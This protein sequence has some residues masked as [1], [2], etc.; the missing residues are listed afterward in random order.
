MQCSDFG[1]FL[2][3]NRKGL[4]RWWGQIFLELLSAGEG[5]QTAEKSF[6]WITAVPDVWKS[7]QA[8]KNKKQNFASAQLQE[9]VTSWK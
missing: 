6:A 1:Y 3:L 7:Q 9:K 4:W 8:Q 2:P 5:M